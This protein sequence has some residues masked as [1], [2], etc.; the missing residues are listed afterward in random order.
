[1]TF[2]RSQ[3]SQ[4]LKKAAC[5]VA[6][7]FLGGCTVNSPR[8]VQDPYS[9]YSYSPSAGPWNRSQKRGPY[10]P[11]PYNVP[12]NGPS[13]PPT[14][15][16]GVP[17]YPYPA[18]SAPQQ[19][20]SVP[21]TIRQ[22]CVVSNTR[23]E[24]IRRED[25]VNYPIL[26]SLVESIKMDPML[27]GPDKTGFIAVKGDPIMCVD[28]SPSQGAGMDVKDWQNGV[29]VA[30][31]RKPNL[32]GAGHCVVGDPLPLFYFPGQVIDR[33]CYTA[34]EIAQKVQKDCNSGRGCF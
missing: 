11:I 28:F 30:L 22:L 13:Y 2:S 8:H 10:I 1:M 21:H 9:V 5:F 14:S 6:A 3:I 34:P 25:P 27:A 4:A 31:R 15:P 32:I 16:G 20:P 12:P 26:K 17:G 29:I 19:Q 24:Q 18:P 7:S 33:S 23:L